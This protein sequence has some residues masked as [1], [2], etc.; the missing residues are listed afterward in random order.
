MSAAGPGN[1]RRSRRAARA[2]GR[3][4]I[5]HWSAAPSPAAAAAAER[6]AAWAKEDARL[7]ETD[8]RPGN[9]VQQAPPMVSP[10]PRLRTA[11]VAVVLA[12]VLAG[13][14]AAAAVAAVV[15]TRHT[16]DADPS[17]SSSPLGALQ[18]SRTA[19]DRLHD[20]TDVGD[21]TGL[22]FYGLLVVAG[23]LVLRWQVV[24]I[25]N[26]QALWIERPRYTPVAAGWCWVVPI[27]ALFGPKKAYGDAWRAAEPLDERI[28]GQTW[29]D[30]PVPGLFTAWWAAWVIAGLLEPVTLRLPE[31]TLGESETVW[32]LEAVSGTIHVAAGVL[33]VM[34]LTRLTARHDAMVDVV[35]AERATD[36]PSD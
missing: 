18:V 32:V 15:Q 20:V 8:G 9:A 2:D 17:G 26:Q 12:T 21:V 30:R 36:P 35:A 29:T 31:T 34:V 22:V 24:P 10:R 28:P 19:V 5:E 4:R 27:W 1:G 23:L 13:V 33:F 11:R 6:E 25:R 3:E 16:I 14:H 7:R